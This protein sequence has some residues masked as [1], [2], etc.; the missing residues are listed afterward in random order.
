MTEVKDKSSIGFIR[1]I[2][3]NTLHL[4]SLFTFSIVF[5]FSSTLYANEIT[6][7]EAQ[8]QNNGSISLATDV[9]LPAQSTAE[10]LRTYFLIGETS[11]PSVRTVPQNLDS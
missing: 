5:L 4:L 7:L 11:Q 6:W 9:S 1:R 2:S 10:V 3:K 8:A